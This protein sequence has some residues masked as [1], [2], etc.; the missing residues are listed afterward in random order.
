M[1]KARHAGLV[2]AKWLISLAIGAVFVWLSLDDLPSSD[3]L[4]ELRFASGRLVA[5]TWSLKLWFVPL[6][7]LTLVVMHFFR[8]WRWRPLLKPLCDVDFW[9]LN[10]I[11]SV[12]F[13]AVFVL[14]MRFGELV[15]PALLPTV[16]PVR[17]SAALATIVLERLVDGVMVAGFLAVALVFMPRSEVGSYEELKFATIAALCLFLAAVALLVLLFVFRQRVIAVVSHMT[18]RMAGHRIGTRLTGM[19]ERFTTGLSI[20][21]DARNTLWFMLGSLMYWCS[22]GVGLWVLAQGFDGLHV[23]MLL[24]FAMMSTIVVGMM[25]PNAPANVGSFWFFLLLPTRLYGA[26]FGTPQAG[27]AFALTVWGLQFLQL[28]LFGGWFIANGSVPFRGLF[29]Q[30]DAH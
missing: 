24:A 30:G 6:Y 16:A 10:R 23:D 25:I 1:G 27:L 4:S 2:A 9:R 26:S 22:N 14:P 12:G 21:P 5:G 3:V 15:R 28:I 20:F 29:S 17:R 11:C 8:V 7:F 19:A 13:L 18:T